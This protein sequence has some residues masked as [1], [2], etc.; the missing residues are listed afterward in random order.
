M[1][2]KGKPPIMDRNTGAEAPKRRRDQ[3]GWREKR[4]DQREARTERLS[5]RTVKKGGD[6]ERNRKRGG[7]GN[8]KGQR[9]EGEGGRGAGKPEWSEEG[10]GEELKGAVSNP[11]V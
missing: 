2:E 3:R 11:R 1:D 5:R 6:C 7:E 8:K 4:G 9:G 10:G